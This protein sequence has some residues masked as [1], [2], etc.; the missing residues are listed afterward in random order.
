MRL[1]HGFLATPVMC[2]V[3]L[4]V[5]AQVTVGEREC[6]DVT[7]HSDFLLTCTL[8]PG[9]GRALPVSVT[10]GRQSGGGNAVATMADAVGFRLQFD[11]FNFDPVQQ[12]RACAVLGHDTCLSQRR[13][14]PPPPRYPRLILA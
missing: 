12:V 11:P 14:A 7:R 3:F 9:F 4:V 10:L 6:V 1:T 5:V 13:T 8:M 2:C